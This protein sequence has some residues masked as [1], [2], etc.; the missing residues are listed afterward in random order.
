MMNKTIVL[1][2]MDGTLTEPRQVFNN[3]SLEHSLYLLTNRGVEIGIV[4]GSGIRY[5]NQQMSVFLDRSTCRYKTHLLPCNGTQYLKPPVF[6][7]ESHKLIYQNSMENKLGNKNYRDLIKEIIG[8][9]YEMSDHP[10]PLSGHFVDYRGSMINWSPIGREA[11]TDQRKEFIKLDKSLELRSRQITRFKQQLEWLQLDD[12]VVIK[13]GGDTSFDIYPVGWDKTY[14][15][16]HFQGYDI[17]FVGDRCKP[18]GNDYELFTHC[19]DQGFEST[20]PDHTVDI[21]NT[22][23]E[24]MRRKQ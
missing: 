5:L 24:K 10:I 6:S 15:L 16:K 14:A 17:W 1:F 22:I 23:I 8:S 9:Q 4:T 3:K 2:D 18:N 19:G 20:G 21:I 12:L 13:L 11:S 7:T